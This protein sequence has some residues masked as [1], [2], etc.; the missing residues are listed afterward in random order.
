MS[1][2]VPGGGRFFLSAERAERA[3]GGAGGEGEETCVHGEADREFTGGGVRDSG[4]RKEIWDYR[5][6]G[7]QR[8]ADGG[9]PENSRSDRCGRAGSRGFHRGD[10]FN[11]SA[12]GAA[13]ETG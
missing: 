8:A 13:A 6:G 10:F 5:Y 11:Q 9:Y 1:G 4:A 7:A 2:A 3:D 12:A